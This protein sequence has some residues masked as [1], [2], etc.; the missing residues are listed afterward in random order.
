MERDGERGSDN[1]I[2]QFELESI[3]V[4]PDG[5]VYGDGGIRRERN[6]ERH[7]EFLS[8][9]RRDAGANVTAI[10]NFRTI[11]HEWNFRRK[12]LHRGGV[13][14]KQRQFPGELVS[15]AYA[16]REGF[17]LERF[18]GRSDGGAQPFRHDDADGDSDRRI[19]RHRNV[20]LQRGA[21]QY[22][23]QHFAKPSYVEWQR[24]ELHCDNSCKQ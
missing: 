10:G 17:F 19:Y 8:G 4:G 13:Q 3:D 23:L 18:S 24:G 9:W 12:P 15:D 5:H 22:E 16:N 1:D 11:F 20:F 7:G 6:A 2:A 14:F 21:G